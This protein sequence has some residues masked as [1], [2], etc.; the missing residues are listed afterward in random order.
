MP[1]EHR[2]IL[3]HADEP[4][5]SRDIDCYLKHDGYKVLRQSFGMKPEEIHSEVMEVPRP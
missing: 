2:I 4:G 5:Y 3:K 1:E